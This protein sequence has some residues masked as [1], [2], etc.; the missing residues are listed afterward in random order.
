MRVLIVGCGYVGTELGMR[1]AQAG[2]EVWGLKRDPATLPDAVRPIEGD[3]FDFALESRLPVVDQVVYAVS[4]DVPSLDHYR[5]AYV[6]GVENLLDALSGLNDPPGRLIF[7]SSTAVYGDA[8]GAWVDES[9]PPS[10]EDF[11]GAVLLEGEERF[12]DANIPSVCLRLGGIYGPG[13]TR[14]LERVRL[15]EALCPAK[16]P[17]WSNRIHRNDAAGV[18]M[19]LMGKDDLNPVYVGVDEEPASIC[20]VYEYV[21]AL[22]GAPKPAVDSSN[23]ARRPGKRCSNRALRASGYEFEFPTYREGYRALVEVERGRSPS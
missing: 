13:R 4:A 15:G 18:L 23:R 9:I 14:L 12:L 22:V 11:R 10:P 7:L 5:K 2:H 17:V 19:H 16:G 6:E 21:A 1:L 20:R 8:D 3:L